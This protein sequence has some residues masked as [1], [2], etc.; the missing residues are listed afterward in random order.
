MTI[1]EKIQQYKDAIQEA[2]ESIENK[3]LPERVYAV[4]EK[5]IATLLKK[6]MKLQATLKN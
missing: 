6:Q 5:T 2:E 3:H 4:V 1:Q